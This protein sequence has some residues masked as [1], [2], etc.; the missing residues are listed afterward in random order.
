M[1]QCGD[2]WQCFRIAGVVIRP[3][4][5]SHG[6]VRSAEL[7]GTVAA[8]VDAETIGRL[9]AIAAT[10]NRPGSQIV[11]VAPRTLLSLSPGARR[12]LYAIDGAA[13]GKRAFAGQQ[14]GRAVLNAYERI[15]DARHMGR[16]RSGCQ[17]ASGDGG[18]H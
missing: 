11:A 16:P 8:H 14:A 3:Q 5:T 6:T 7:A 17:R 4:L 1:A 12:A 15:L 2:G 13:E 10:E 9:R 18:R